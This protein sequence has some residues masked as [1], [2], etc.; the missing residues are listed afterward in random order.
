[1]K[2]RKL[3]DVLT[4]EGAT[5]FAQAV[6]DYVRGFREGARH[7]P[8]WVAHVLTLYDQRRLPYAHVTKGGT[9]KCPACR[10]PIAKCSVDD[11]HLGHD[12]FSWTEDIGSSRH[13]RGVR[14]H[15]LVIDGRYETD[16]HDESPAAG[17]VTCGCGQDFV[18]P[19]RIEPEFV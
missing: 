9:L 7:T 5:K 17:R 18:L 4:G 16:G 12:D 10:T 15:T 19:P 14:G 13:V 11:S 1:V 2:S 3:S 6:L 8:P